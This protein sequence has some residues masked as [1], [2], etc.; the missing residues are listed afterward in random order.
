[1]YRTLNHSPNMSEMWQ[2]DLPHANEELRSKHLE[3]R[4]MHQT[5]IFDV[6][7]ALNV[8]AVRVVGGSIWILHLW[9]FLNQKSEQFEWKGLNQYWCW[10]C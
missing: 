6:Q 1:L 5:I 7:N 4:N 10:L 9:A 2:H 8:R 3:L